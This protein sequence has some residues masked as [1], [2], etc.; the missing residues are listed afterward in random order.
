[1]CV[2]DHTARKRQQGAVR[3][4]SMSATAATRPGKRDGP[5]AHTTIKDRRKNMRMLRELYIERCWHC[6]KPARM[7]DSEKC[8]GCN[9]AVYCGGA[10]RAADKKGIHG[11]MCAR[12][13]G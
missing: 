13:M 4:T 8:P 3:T 7:L 6:N 11:L 10:C 9:I 1:M 2:P 12:M 5:R